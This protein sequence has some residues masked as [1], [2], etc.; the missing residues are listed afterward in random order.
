MFGLLLSELISSHVR[1]ISLVRYWI[2]AIGYG[3]FS[4]FFCRVGS[5]PSGECCATYRNVPILHSFCV[6]LWLCFCCLCCFCFNFLDDR[7][8]GFI[9]M[10]FMPVCLSVRLPLSSSLCLSLT[11]SSFCCCYCCSFSLVSFCISTKYL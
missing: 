3:V 6:R 4:L 5:R 11:V 10:G 2:L 1:H 8:M 7:F 9:S